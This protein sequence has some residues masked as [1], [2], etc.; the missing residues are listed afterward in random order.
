[1]TQMKSNSRVQREIDENLKR[2]F[3]SVA[4]EDVPDQFSELLAKLRAAESAKSGDQH[5]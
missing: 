2:A 1:M 4:S 5:D 3:D